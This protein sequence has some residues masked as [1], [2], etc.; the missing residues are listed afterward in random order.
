[1]TQSEKPLWLVTGAAGTLGAELVRQ[2]LAAGND[3][4]ALDKNEAALNQLHDQLAEQGRPVPV[5]LPLDLAGA[6]PADYE[7]VASTVEAQFGRLDGLIH[8]AAAFVALRPLAHQPAEEWMRILQ[9]GL[10]GPQLLSNA[11]LG[12]MQA[13]E[14]ARLVFISDRHC[15]ERPGHWAAY[16]VA[17]A[18]RAWMARTLARELGA[19]GPRVMEIDPGPFFSA[20]RSAAWPAARPEEFD[21]IE[22]VA[23]RVLEQINKEQDEHVH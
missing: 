2:L 19:A 13:T 6:G 12:L 23:T 16:G 9:T 21:A 10:T 3:C 14:G 17:Q 22:Q 4:I 11:L 1:M 15:L 20:L 5:L 18:G 8:N 7:Q